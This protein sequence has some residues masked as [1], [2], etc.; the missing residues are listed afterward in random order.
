AAAL[1]AGAP[2]ANRGAGAGSAAAQVSSPGF[3]PAVLKWAQSVAHDLQAHR[4][5]SLV[6]AG[7]GQAPTLHALAHRMNEA[8]GNAGRTIVY[9]DPVESEPIDQPESL[10]DLVRNMDAGS[11]DLLVVVGGNPVYTAPVDLKIADAMGKVTLRVHLGLFEDETS[12]LCHWHIPEA[13]FLE[14][15]SD[16]RACDGTVSIVQPVIAPLYGG[17]SAHELFAAM[18]DRPERSSYDIVREYWSQQSLPV[19]SGLSR[20]FRTQ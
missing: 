1:D 7:D 8:L 16:A 6:I 11:V 17:K 4:G 10:R 20:T 14:A 2:A 15:W 3:A 9:S 12:E 19:G 18:S 5:A 13:H